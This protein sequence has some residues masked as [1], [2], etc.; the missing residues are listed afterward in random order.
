M[1]TG[2]ILCCDFKGKPLSCKKEGLLVVSMD[3]G[4][5]ICGLREETPLHECQ[6]W[7]RGL[8]VMDMCSV[9]IEGTTFM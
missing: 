6:S 1:L 2:E 8:L 5:Y 9:G 3:I 4:D 7:K